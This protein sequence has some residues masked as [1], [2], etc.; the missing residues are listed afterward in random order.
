MCVH[1]G[2]SQRSTAW[3]RPRIWGAGAMLMWRRCGEGPGASSRH[4]T[5]VAPRTCP[6]ETSQKKGDM[7]TQNHAGLIT[8]L[9][10]LSFDDHS[11]VE[12]L[13]CTNASLHVRRPTVEKLITPT[14]HTYYTT[15]H[16]TLEKSLGLWRK[17]FSNIFLLRTF[18]R[19][20]PGSSK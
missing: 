5:H 7:H 9:V 1:G 17:N 13:P 18:Y 2:L 4:N 8:R 14:S 16:A 6:G 20:P 19:L 3:G 10:L 11:S 15:T 12:R